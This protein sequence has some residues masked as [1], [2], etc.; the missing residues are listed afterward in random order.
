MKLAIARF[1]TW[2]AS[3]AW[4]WVSK[5]KNE[6]PDYAKMFGYVIVVV[7]HYQTLK[8][9][10]VGVATREAMKKTLESGHVT[11][12]SR[13]RKCLWVKGETSGN[14][15]RVV[16]ILDDCDSDTFLILVDPV[17][18]TCHTGADSCFELTDQSPRLL[19][20]GEDE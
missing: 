18:P 17:G 20:E 8:V 1:L 4:S 14:F 15:L 9:L 16:K 11:F 6:R 5:G 19:K 3:A 12:W 13:T 10:M 7:Q 2:L